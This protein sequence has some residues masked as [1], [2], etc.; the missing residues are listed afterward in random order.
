MNRQSSA[1]DLAQRRRCAGVREAGLASI[2]SANRWMVSGA[3]VLAGAL[4][5]LTAHAFHAGISASP[6]SPAV[7]RA[8]VPAHSDDGGGSSAPLAAP[9]SAPAPAAPAPGA[10]AAPVS[11]GS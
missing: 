5:A 11:G 10:P 6:R 9:S 3:L 8:S 7:S 2:A 4:S 1:A